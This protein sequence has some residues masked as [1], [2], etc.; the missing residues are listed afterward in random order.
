MTAQERRD[1][2]KGWT[3]DEEDCREIKSPVETNGGRGGR[4]R[5]GDEHGRSARQSDNKE[6]EQ[7]SDTRIHRQRDV[8]RAIEDQRPQ[9]VGESWNEEGPRQI[10]R[11]GG[12]GEVSII[13]QQA[14]SQQARPEQSRK[15]DIR[16]K[17][18]CRRR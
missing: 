11:E 7:Q 3:V 10:A 14:K 4:G 17:A 8:G 15:E 16:T 9:R 12:W 5:L 1:R 6:H 18:I 2:Q 13:T